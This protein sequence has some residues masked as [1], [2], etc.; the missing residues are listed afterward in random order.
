MN[1]LCGVGVLSTPYAVKEGGWL[2]LSILLIFA[3]LSYYTGILLRS[4]LDSQPGIETYPDIGQAA[5]GR[6]GR[7]VISVSLI[8]SS[9]FCLHLELKFQ[10]IMIDVFT[11]QI[12][13]KSMSINY[14]LMCLSY[15]M[16]FMQIILYVELYVSILLNS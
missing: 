16:L 10:N 8:T 5:F 6:V 15:C 1:V 9:I 4:C 13:R 3:V 11:Y 12:K 14:L 7:I 2:G